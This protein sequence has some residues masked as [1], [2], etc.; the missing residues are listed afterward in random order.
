MPHPARRNA[1]SSNVLCRTPTPGKQPTRI[2]R[3]K[4]DTVRQAVLKVL[5]GQPDGVLFGDLSKLVAAEL[6]AP[7]RKRLGSI[8]WYT[9]VVKLE[10]EVRGEI[11]RVEDVSPQRLR[12]AGRKTSRTK[13]VE[14]R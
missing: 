13:K 1:D 7:A 3:W 10:L 4:F 9:T 2:D 8:N 12:L 6:D 5:A 14:G 11:A